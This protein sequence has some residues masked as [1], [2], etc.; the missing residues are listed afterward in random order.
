MINSDQLE[1][2][3]RFLDGEISKDTLAE[4]LSDLSPEAL[5]TEIAAMRDMR[6]AVEAAGLRDQLTAVLPK[7]APK[8]AKVRRLV[9]WRQG[10][11][12]AASVLVLIIAYVF[13]PGSSENGGLYAQYEYID[14]GLPVLMSQSEQHAMY[15]A[16]T[17]Y[18][19]EDY[20]TAISKLS[21][22]QT[23]GINNDTISYYLG[24]SYL[25]EKQ[26]STAMENLAA[27]TTEAG[28]FRARAEW[29]T[30]LAALQQEDLEQVRNLLP[31][32]LADETHPFHNKAQQLQADLSQ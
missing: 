7:V 18:S 31:S 32:I 14:P 10:L 28:P 26:A 23:Q 3:E 30:L 9:S 15:D 2:I 1:Q 16:L 5:E 21:A 12:I 6:T 8:P 4:A 27:L 20:A 13:W 25:Y 29:L 22:L 19:E 17:Y 24:A 11:A